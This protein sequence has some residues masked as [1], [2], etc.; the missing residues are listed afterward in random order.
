MSLGIVGNSYGS[1]L[2]STQKRKVPN[3]W[4]SPK[5]KTPQEV[6]REDIVNFN[7]ECQQKSIEKP[8]KERTLGDW[9]NVTLATLHK[10]LSVSPKY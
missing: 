5:I 9:A 4:C 1:N 7:K 6:M 2:M 3:H 8:A 10:I